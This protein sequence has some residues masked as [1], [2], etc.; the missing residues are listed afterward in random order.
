[1]CKKMK[2]IEI[3]EGVKFLACRVIPESA[4]GREAVLFRAKIWGE[5][6]AVRYS[7]YGRELRMYDGWY[8]KARETTAYRI[9]MNAIR[10]HTGM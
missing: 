1:M 6:K 8:T 7:W 5:S 9:I 3:V 10:M 2:P 4:G